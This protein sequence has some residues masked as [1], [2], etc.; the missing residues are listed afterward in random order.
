MIF[1]MKKKYEK[2]ENRAYI[3]HKYQYLKDAK[4]KQKQIKKKFDYT[5][6]IQYA[7]DKTR[8]N[9]SF[10]FVI[11]PKERQPT[12]T[13]QISFSGGIR[14]KDF[15]NFTGLTPKRRNTYKPQSIEDKIQKLIDEGYTQAAFSKKANANKFIKMWKEQSDVK[16]V[17]TERTN[18]PTIEEPNRKVKAYYVMI[19]LK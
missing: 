7:K 4:K 10:Y 17:R 19:D 5:A 16:N 11:E 18:G 1:N 13:Q 8:K 3:K 6:K 12:R 9:D 15:W 14:M 2:E